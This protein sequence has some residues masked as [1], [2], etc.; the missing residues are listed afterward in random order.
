MLE[1]ATELRGMVFLLLVGV[2][3]PSRVDA[4]TIPVDSTDFAVV[5]GDGK[6][7]LIEAMENARQAD[8]GYVDC[9]T[10]SSASNVIELAAGQTYV[11]PGARDNAGTAAALGLPL[12][13]RP[14]TINGHGATLTRGPDAGAFRLL[15]VHASALT[16]NDLTIKDMVL[17][18]GADGAVYNDNGALDI[19]RSTLE[20]TRVEAGGTGGGAVTSRACVPAILASCP[21]N[22]QASLVI[23]DSVFDDNESRSTGGAF[24]AG[25]GVNTYAVG[26]GATNTAT[27]VRSRFHGNKAT[28]QGAGVS[29]AAYDSGAASTT[30]IESS[31]ITGNTTTGGVTPAF[32]GG[33]AN[34]VGKV[35]TVSAAN[36]VATMNITSTTIASNSAL[37]DGYGGGI[38]NELDC[39]FMVSCGGGAVVRLALN[40]VTLYGNAS[41]R[42][43]SG[44]E[45]GGGIWSNS[46]D[47]TGTVE[48]KVRD[49]LI[50]GNLANGTPANCRI[51]NNLPGGV[52]GY[53]IASDGSCGA[54]FN[55]FTLAQIDLG[56]LNT[57]G[58]TYYHAPRRGSAAI[59]K[60]TCSAAADQTGTVRPI[61]VACDV[62]AIE[63][64]AARRTIVSDFDGD[65]RSDAGI[66]RPSAGSLALW[67]VP[68]SGGAAAFQIYF[69]ASGDIP[70]PADYDG[71]ARTDAVTWSP[72]T[73]LW[74][75]PRTGAGTL[76]TQFAMGQEGDV[77]VPC[78]YDGDGAVDPA[79]YRPS[80][81]MWLGKRADGVSVVLNTNLGLA[82]GDVPIPADY[83]GDG[84]C[85]PA[86]MRPGVGPGGS[87][88]WYSVPSGGGAA[89]QVFVGAWGDVPAPGD[90]DGDGR[91]DAV[92]FRPSTG[93]WY[94]PRTGTAQIAT[95]LILG[96]SGDVPVPGDYDGNGTTDPAIYRPSSGLLYGINAAGRMVVLDTNLGVAAGD[97]PTG[98]R[99]GY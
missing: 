29:N 84:R 67:Y 27:I 88:L 13:S 43:P 4:S 64:S 76:V 25:A 57:A 58:L 54:A 63:A 9:P 47:P 93:L 65:G 12:V 32:G 98:K 24:G 17:P 15:Y 62:G 37:G 48:F 41:G 35:Y 44:V 90:Y 3:V 2:A 81:G 97:V 14:L 34:F 23:A 38:F 89:L 6:C 51:M 7:T 96:V 8:G 60:A 78:D 80:T 11:V 5:Q 53:N 22:G 36:A 75:G 50:A 87:N 10:G 56:G 92:V 71:D 91:A 85:D 79:V 59:D 31:S 20:G 94:G 18:N 40:S 83:N 28:N 95:Q 70:V 49:S 82:A 69:G 33:I 52:L 72:A 73:G 46:N 19:H 1:S 86:I 55:V 45:R 21:A 39:G 61:S 66:V 42:D 16:L 26:S 74:H 68:P 30:T 99:P 77:P